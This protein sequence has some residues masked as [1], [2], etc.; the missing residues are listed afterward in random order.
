MIQLESKTQIL[1]C[2]HFFFKIVGKLELNALVGHAT[3]AALVSVI[4]L[5]FRRDVSSLSFIL[6]RR[7]GRM[8]WS[9][10]TCLP[11]RLLDERT[12]RRLGAGF[13][14]RASTLFTLRCVKAASYKYGGCHLK[15]SLR[16]G[17]WRE[18]MT[19]RNQ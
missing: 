10:L 5:F 3:D 13:V 1:H 18:G 17:S 19:T 7:R 9:E 12:S 4:N 11:G 6:E 14:M 2:T 8:A 16:R 15:L